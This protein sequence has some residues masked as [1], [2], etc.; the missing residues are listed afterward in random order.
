M[1]VYD[2]TPETAPVVKTALGIRTA[3]IRA[4]RSSHEY[5]VA[6]ELY[7]FQAKHRRIGNSVGEPCWL[8]GE[9][10]DYRLA[11]PHARS[12]SL[13]HKITVHENP[14]LMLDP[15]N[16][17]SSHLECNNIRGTDEPALDLGRPMEVW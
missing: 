15:L 1:S 2:D 10:I 8:C 7:R 14:E 3:N 16:F 12:W 5:Q 13:D 9:D 4:I 6:R 17:A 11:Y